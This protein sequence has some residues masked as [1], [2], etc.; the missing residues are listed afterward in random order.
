MTAHPRVDPIDG[1]LIF[2]ST[3]MFDAPHVRY[4]VIDRY[5]NHLVWK[6]GIDIG[7]AKMWAGSVHLCAGA[8]NTRM[9]DF[10]ATRT[11]TI[12]LNLPLTLSPANLMYLP[13][14]PLIHFDRTLPSEFVVFPRLLRSEAT[15]REPIRFS[16]P[17]PSLIFHTANAWDEYAN[18]ELVAVNML[19]C[20]FHS[21]K[22]VYAAGAVDIPAVEQA[23][24]ADDVVRLHYY[25][26]V[27]PPGEEK[28][29]VISHSF[30]LT[31]IPFEFPSVPTD[32]GMSEARYV[33]GCT[34]KS[35]S[36]DERLGGAAKVDC[37]VKVDV[38]TLIE[39]GKEAGG[40]GPAD[41][42]SS[43]QIMADWKEGKRGPLEIFACPDGWF[44]QET[45]F[46]PRKDA[47]DEDDGYLLTYGE[48]DVL[49]ATKAE[50]SL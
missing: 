11:H 16:E 25:R 27:M 44:A 45:R 43:A 36:F 37:I 24:G 48:W 46:V 30:P 29:G 7:R 31:V 19:G 39:M 9:H 6:E 49:E 41:D 26:F 40:S 4:S 17:R 50:D 8:N 18:G 32:L 23:A 5:G 10:A 28:T 47:S 1:S 34:M 14:V 12:L 2:Y 20:R 21:A 38:K 3:Q 35:G 13:P 42:R 15:P 22:L 33:Y